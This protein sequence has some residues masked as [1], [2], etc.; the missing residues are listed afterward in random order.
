MV[1]HSVPLTR[2]VCLFVLCLLSSCGRLP[3]WSVIMPAAFRYGEY[4]KAQ[5]WLHKYGGTLDGVM[6]HMA[7][8]YNGYR[9]HPNQTVVGCTSPSRVA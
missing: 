3:H 4:I 5:P 9:W 7:Q 6:Q 8:Q 1:A 2:Q